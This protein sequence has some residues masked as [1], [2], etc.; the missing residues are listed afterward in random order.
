MCHFKSACTAATRFGEVT[1]LSPTRTAFAPAS[2]SRATSVGPNTPLSATIATSSG[3]SGARATPLLRVEAAGLQVSACI[4][5]F[6]QNFPK[7]IS[8]RDDCLE[9]ALF[10]SAYPDAFEL[11]GGE[12]KT[13]TVFLAF[14]RQPDVASP[15][16][17]MRQPRVAHTT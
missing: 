3:A 13:H 15:L 14:E 16:E 8:V 1:R 17:W 6:W 12:Q 10:P 11:Q 2:N 4:P 5:E 7:A 9:V